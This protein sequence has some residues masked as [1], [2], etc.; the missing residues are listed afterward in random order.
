MIPVFGTST[1]SFNPWI[2]TLISVLIAICSLVYAVTKDSKKEV[3]EGSISA[4]TVIVK[5][6]NLQT[7]MNRMSDS[8]ASMQT[9]FENFDHRLTVVETQL[10]L[11]LVDAKNIDI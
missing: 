5:L 4:T 7:T 1:V 11:G 9:K 2:L 10:K 6:E 8:F 3:K